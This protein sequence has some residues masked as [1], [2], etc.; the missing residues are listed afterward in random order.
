MEDWLH[1][2][3]LCVPRVHCSVIL[4]SSTA[5]SVTTSEH[6]RGEREMISGEWGRLWPCSIMRGANTHGWQSLDH[7]LAITI[8]LSLLNWIRCVPVKTTTT[9]KTKQITLES[10]SGFNCTC[11]N[12]FFIIYCS[13]SKS[14]FWAIH[15]IHQ[16]PLSVWV[17]A[18][19][20][21]SDYTKCSDS[22]WVLLVIA[23]CKSRSNHLPRVT[24]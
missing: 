10:V 21:G 3:F 9:T 20:L 12:T 6:I 16:Y 11:I 18:W 22:S 2:G 24:D 15:K 19:K 5:V 8:T 7:G 13:W 17:S 14:H 4:L 1:W 23:P